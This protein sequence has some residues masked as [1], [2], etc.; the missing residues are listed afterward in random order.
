MRPAIFYCGFSGCNLADLPFMK[1]RN[2]QIE[3][4]DQLIGYV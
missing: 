2:A 4:I 1:K 3:F